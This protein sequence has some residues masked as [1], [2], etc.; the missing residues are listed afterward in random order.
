MRSIKY[1]F[2]ALCAFCCVACDSGDIEDN[3]VN[4]ADS[5]KTVKLVGSLSGLD[6]WDDTSFTVA[7]AGFSDNSKYAVMQRVIT[8]VGENG[9]VEYV[10]NNV[11][12]SITSV[13]LAITNSLRKRIITLASIDMSEYEDNS[14]SD[15]IYMEIGS[16]EVDLF[17]CMQYGIFN[18]ACISCHGGNG[19]SAGN[20]N[21]TNNYAYEQLV[22]VAS[23]QKE[24][25]TR[26]ISGD[27]ENSLLRQI[28]HEGGE[29]I[30]HYNH[31]EVLSSHFK[32]NLDEV[33]QLIDDWINSLGD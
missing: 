15:T 28:L 2:I 14:P 32:S 16:V 12:S 26:V 19:R 5:G 4:I 30:L 31:T 8:S 25:C 10:L 21:L 20:L 6:S 33:K 13:E 3:S 1:L 17:G 9:E 22:D 7:L 18:N 29:N 23:T 24:G 27:P 11:S